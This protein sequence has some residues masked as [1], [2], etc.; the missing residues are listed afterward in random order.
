VDRRCRVNVFTFSKDYRI[1]NLFRQKVLPTH[2]PTLRKSVRGLIVLALL[3]TSTARGQ[4]FTPEH[5]VVQEMVNRGLNFL[6][7]KKSAPGSYTNSQGSTLLAGYCV[8]KVNADPSDPLVQDAVN[9]ALELANGS[10]NPAF[11]PEEKGTYM[12]ALAG[13]L[14]PTVDVDAYGAQT[15]L[16]RDYFM[17]KQLPHGGFGYPHGPDAAMGDISQT[18]YVML[19]L[20]TMNQLGVEVPLDNIVRALNFLLLAQ[21][22]EGAWPYM[23]DTKAVKGAVTNSLGAAGL[24]AM[25]IGGDLLGL[26]RSKQQEAQE[27]EGI[28]PLAFHRV[29]TESQRPK[30]N[31]EKGRLDASSKKCESWFAANPYVRDPNFYYVYS[32]ERYESFLEITKGKQSKSPEWYNAGVGLLQKSQATDGSWGSSQGDR[33]DFLPPD[34]STAFSILFLIRSTQ[35]AI[36]ELSEGVNQGVGEIPDDVRSITLSNG[37]IA[38]KNEKNTIDDALKMLEDESKVEGEDS[39][40]PDR[41]LLAQ[42][43]KQRKVQLNRFVRLLNAQDFKARQIAAKMLGRGDDLDLVPSLIYAL[44][45]PDSRV[46]IFAE[47]SLRLISRQLDTSFLPKKDKLSDQDKAKASMQWKKWYA[48]VRPDYVF[49]D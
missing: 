46:P 24:S 44:T 25:L 37:K 41:M 22:P 4:K 2:N 38:N 47:E 3:L 13:M 17:R 27:E 23:S 11:H 34:V 14:L 26:Y 10:S 45:D 16:I 5:P 35:K 7:S 32:K 30:V 49:V 9:V 43:P 1:L 21:Q 28:I 20:W 48:T 8:F 40:A 36:G 18:Q 42:D 6:H 39:L 15:K 29:V 19:S 33:S 12:I 31:F